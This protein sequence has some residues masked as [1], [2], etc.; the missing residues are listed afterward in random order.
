[1]RCLI[2]TGVFSGSVSIVPSSFQRKRSYR[3]NR[4]IASPETAHILLD[5][6]FQVRKLGNVLG[7][8]RVEVEVAFFDEHHL[9]D[10]VRQKSKLSPEA[11]THSCGC[12]NGLGHT[13]YAKHSVRSE[14][15]QVQ[16]GQRLVFR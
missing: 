11:V 8:S 9:V 4:Q 12:T 10:D 5:K 6:D 14:L 15:F 1:M 7:N 3:R 2:V 13:H 16:E